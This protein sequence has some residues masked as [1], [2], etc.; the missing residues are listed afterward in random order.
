MPSG[1]FLPEQFQ[2]ICGPNRTLNTVTPTLQQNVF[3]LR[4]STISFLDNGIVLLKIDDNS[5]VQVEDSIEQHKILKKNYIP[6]KKFRILVDPGRYTSISTEAREYSSRPENNNLT[7]A[8]AV[9]IKSLAQRIV[10]NFMINFV[11][12]QN[13]RMRM[14]ESKEKAIEWLTGLKE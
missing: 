14:F 12:K 6:G 4:N 9:I 11:Q 13:M 3:K 2:L 8:T 10:I 7:L 5:E 1:T